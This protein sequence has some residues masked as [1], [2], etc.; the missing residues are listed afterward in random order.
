MQS[1]VEGWGCYCGTTRFPG[2]HPM[3]SIV[4]GWGSYL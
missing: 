3:R 1:I 2:T 4:E